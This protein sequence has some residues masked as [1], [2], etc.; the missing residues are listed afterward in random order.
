[1]FVFLKDVD[2]EAKFFSDQV[3]RLRLTDRVPMIDKLDGIW[4]WKETV[5]IKKSC[6]QYA[7]KVQ[8]YYSIAYDYR[9]NDHSVLKL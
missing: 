5:L 6:I 9:N 2:Q 7:K 8:R 1:M 4:S 3:E